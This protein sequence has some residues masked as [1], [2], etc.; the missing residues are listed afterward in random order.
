MQGNNHNDL[1]DEIERRDRQLDEIAEEYGRIHAERERLRDRR[2]KRN[3]PARLSDAE[4]EELQERRRAEDLTWQ[5]RRAYMQRRTAEIGKRALAVIGLAWLITAWQERRGETIIAM[6]LTAAAATGTLAVLPDGAGPSTWIDAGSP[7][8]AVGTPAPAEPPKDAGA[9]L[10]GA[11]APPL[12]D[13]PPFG[14]GEPGAGATATGTAEPSPTSSPEVTPTPSPPG[15]PEPTATPTR[16]PPSP[17][18]T[19]S[20]TATVT[21]TPTSSPSPTGTPTPTPTPT[22]DPLLCLDM[23]N[24]L[25]L[26]ACIDV[27]LLDG[28]LGGRGLYNR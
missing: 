19:S 4:L 21:A 10:P 13:D 14:S 28:I 25:E 16:P 8:V 11:Q 9:S 7:P 17:T 15:T 22:R 23:S 27:P 5:E 2:Q 18:P 3:R 24:L 26:E 1:D 20:P 12:M 6:G